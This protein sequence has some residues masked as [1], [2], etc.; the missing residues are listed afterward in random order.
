[1]GIVGINEVSVVDSR[2]FQQNESS[3]CSGG[4]GCTREIAVGLSEGSSSR[5]HIDTGGQ[6]LDGKVARVVV[7]DSDGVL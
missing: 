2:A 1:M 5:Q 7:G 3:G 4:V 6:D